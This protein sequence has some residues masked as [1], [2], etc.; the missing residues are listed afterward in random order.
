MSLPPQSRSSYPS[1]SLVLPTQLSGEQYLSRI[2]RTGTGKTVNGIISE[3]LLMEARTLL[4][5]RSLAVS[6][7]AVRL[8]FSDTSAFCK[9]FRR[10]AGE[11]PLGFRK[12]LWR[13][14]A[15]PMVMDK[16][17]E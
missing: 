13:E 4:G 14:A 7:V 12:R 16:K 2:V 5:N 3:L 9:F 10:N 8:N 1:Q 11:T 17:E 6:D 15:V